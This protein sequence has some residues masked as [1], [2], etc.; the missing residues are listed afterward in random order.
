MVILL[1]YLLLFICLFVPPALIYRSSSIAGRQKTIWVIGCL[2]S[3]VTFAVLSIVGILLA[4][5][6]G[7]YELTTESMIQG[8]M[9]II[10]SIL[11]IVLF[12]S[13]WVIFF[14]FKSKHTKKRS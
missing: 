14:I 3:G 2:L 10:M 6:F 12:A 7:G 11:N 1:A 4:V 13:P 5:K 8:P 9:A